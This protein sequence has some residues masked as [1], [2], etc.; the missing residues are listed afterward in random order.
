MSKKNHNKPKHNK[1][2]LADSDLLPVTW[3]D[4]SVKVHALLP[5]EQPS[6]Q[7][8]DA[9]T[10]IFQKQIKNSP[11]WGDMIKQFAC[12]QQAWPQKGGG[13]IKT[14]PCRAKIMFME[15]KRGP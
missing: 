3:Q 13:A 10:K 4:D 15:L 14:V 9:M 2:L 7:K 6:Q 1:N 12:P 5:G 8:L 11:L